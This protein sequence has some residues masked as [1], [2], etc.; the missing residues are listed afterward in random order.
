MIN[1]TAISLNTNSP[2]ALTVGSQI[3][4]PFVYLQTGCVKNVSSTGTGV[5]ISKCGLYDVNFNADILGTAAGNVQLQ[6]YEVTASNA[7]PV[8]IPGAEA[9][10][11]V[12]DGDTYSVAFSKTI[13][14]NPSC[15]AVNNTTTLYVQLNTTAATISSANMNVTRLA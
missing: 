9:T 7:T 4:L 1:K 10:V 3:A 15:P 11:T 2:Q 14:V 5:K 8:A 6:L 12:A 13:H